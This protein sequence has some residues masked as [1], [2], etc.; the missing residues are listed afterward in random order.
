MT[1]TRLSDRIIAY[2]PALTLMTII[3]VMS[4]RS[5]IP[6]SPAISAELTAFLGHLFVYALLAV[7]LA[8]AFEIDIEQARR[9]AVLAFALATLYGISDEIH[10]RFVP[11]RYA[12][13]FD[14]LTDSAGAAL[15]VTAYCAYVQIRRDRGAFLR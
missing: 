10:Q 14:V 12:T 15:G 5:S 6:R 13:L 3:F 4:S 1:A 2:A 7:L 11:G 9:R 8:R